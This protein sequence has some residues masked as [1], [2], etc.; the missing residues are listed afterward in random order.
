MKLR[1][2]QG[3]HSKPVCATAVFWSPIYFQ[4]HKL[5]HYCLSAMDGSSRFMILKILE[6]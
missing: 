1:R 4:L 3:P 2:N 5:M 6:L